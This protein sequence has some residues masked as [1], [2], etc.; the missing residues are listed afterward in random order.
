MLW[1][2][3]V[4]WG[5]VSH[6]A[7]V[8]LRCALLPTQALIWCNPE[9]LQ[10]NAASTKECRRLKETIAALRMTCQWLPAHRSGYLRL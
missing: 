10:T 2:L 6:T 9:D 5:R 3:P 7:K 4:G 1:P 8:T